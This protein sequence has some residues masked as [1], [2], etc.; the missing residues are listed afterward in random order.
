MNEDSTL[1]FM[2]VMCVVAWVYI[3]AAIA[4]CFPWFFGVRKSGPIQAQQQRTDEKQI[5]TENA[6]I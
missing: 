4:C 1:L 5:P 6:Q 3:G 2:K